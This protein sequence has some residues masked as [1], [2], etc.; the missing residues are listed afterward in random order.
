MGAPLTSTQH[1]TATEEVWT[2]SYTAPEPTGDIAAGLPR[3][4]RTGLDAHTPPQH[5]QFGGGNISQE[6]EMVSRDTAHVAPRGLSSPARSR[7]A[8]TDYPAPEL[9]VS[10]SSALA[11]SG[12]LAL[13]TPT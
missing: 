11:R 10:L 9:A 7:I 1:Y 13:Q 5:G 3:A 6:Q 8:K 4:A 12:F 2:Q